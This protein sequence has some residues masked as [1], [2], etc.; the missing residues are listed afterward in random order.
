MIFEGRANKVVYGLYVELI[1]QTSTLVEMHV[2]GNITKVVLFFDS[3][4]V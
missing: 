2:D 1:K 4:N 3:F